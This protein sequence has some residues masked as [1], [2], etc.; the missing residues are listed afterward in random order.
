MTS[1]SSDFPQLGPIQSQERIVLLDV[2][3]AF[4]IF[5]MVYSHWPGAYHPDAVGLDHGIIQESVIFIR[6]WFFFGKFH[7][8]FALLMGVGMGI[9]IG[10][11]KEKGRNIIPV[12][13]RRLFFLYL[14]GWLVPVRKL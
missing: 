4:A 3:R 13:L 9:Q 1:A 8:L 14:L 2:V 7:P 10:R 6:R 12:Y 11:A 5:G